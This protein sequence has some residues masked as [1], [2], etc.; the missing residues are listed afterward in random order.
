MRALALG[1]TVVA[2]TI[3]GGCSTSRMVG[4]A[5]EMDGG[6]SLD[7][8]GTWEDCDTRWSFLE[9]GTTTRREYARDC[10]AEGVWSVEG[11]R[12]HIEWTTVCGGDPEVIDGTMA[13]GVESLSLLVDGTSRAA[14]FAASGTPIVT[15]TLIDDLDPSLRTI[16]RVV[17]DP[18]RGAGSGCYWAEDGACGG[19]LSC[20]GRIL[21]WREVEAGRRSASTACTGDCPCGAVLNLTP[22]DEGYDVAYQGVNCDGTFSGSARAF[23]RSE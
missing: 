22:S 19:L 13:F 10:V 8:T 23:P 14:T 15:V 6:P 7:P 5:A 2:I 16:V 18:E 3:A 20:S 12:A 21:Q 11:N 9:D 17:G 1:A 4:D